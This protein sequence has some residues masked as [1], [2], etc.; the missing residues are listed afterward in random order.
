MNIS[1]ANI[2]GDYYPAG[3]RNEGGRRYDRVGVV[4]LRPSGRDADLSARGGVSSGTLREQSVNLRRRG[5]TLP[6]PQ[7]YGP[8]RAFHPFRCSLR[9]PLAPATTRR[10]N[11]PLSRN[12]PEP[13]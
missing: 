13:R 6:W 11:T 2:R 5:R 7:S 9:G 4:G 8:R 1:L 12:V 10:T 3:W